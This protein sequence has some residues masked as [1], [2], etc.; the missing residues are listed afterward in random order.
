M[1]T[2]IKQRNKR[3][4]KEIKTDDLMEMIPK[5]YSEIEIDRV[6]EM[7]EEVLQ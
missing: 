5:H 4:E 1:Y 6:R 2:R 3:K 7:T